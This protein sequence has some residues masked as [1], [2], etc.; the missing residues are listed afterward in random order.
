MEMGSVEVKVTVVKGILGEEKGE[1]SL[2]EVQVILST[3]MREKRARVQEDATLCIG[4]SALRRPLEALTMFLPAS[5]SAQA[6]L[7][8]NFDIT[9]LLNQE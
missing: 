6:A 9:V 2:C 3:Q 1:Q 5:A 4:H 7:M 8:V